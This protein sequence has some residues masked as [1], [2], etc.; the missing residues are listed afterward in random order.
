MNVSRSLNTHLENFPSNLTEN[1]ILPDIIQQQVPLK[2]NIHLPGIKSISLEP[3][4][5][6]AW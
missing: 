1:L 5:D 2:E 4:I 6:G 3:N